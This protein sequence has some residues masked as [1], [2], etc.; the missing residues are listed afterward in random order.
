MMIEMEI[1]DKRVS[2]VIEKRATNNIK[3]RL[4]V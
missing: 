1:E 3:K 4:G 2:H